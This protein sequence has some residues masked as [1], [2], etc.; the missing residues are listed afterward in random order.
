M[1]KITFNAKQKTGDFLTIRST[2][3]NSNKVQK[4]TKV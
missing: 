2:I 1:K 3:L 4:L